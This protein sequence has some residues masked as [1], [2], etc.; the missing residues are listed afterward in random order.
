[1]RNIVSNTVYNVVVSG[2][3]QGS[4][5]AVQMPN[6]PA[7]LVWITAQDDNAG[8]VYLGGAGVTVPDGTTDTTSGI[9]L[10]AGDTI[11]PLPIS[12]LNLL[13]IICDNAGDDV[14]Y[15]VLR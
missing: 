2:E 15:L 7:E 11:G 8:Q 9:Q 14:S 1:M 10:E 6:I 5:T 4:A 13:Y 3:R 12:N